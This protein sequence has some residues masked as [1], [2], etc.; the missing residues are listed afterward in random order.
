ML[1]ELT[2]LVLG[3]GIM[4]YWTKRNKRENKSTAKPKVLPSKT[5]QKGFSPKKLLKKGARLELGR[6]KKIIVQL[7]NYG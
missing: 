4:A 6:W 5:E 1:I 2:L 3:G 7:V